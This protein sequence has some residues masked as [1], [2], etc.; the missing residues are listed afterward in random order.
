MVASTQRQED[1]RDP[2]NPPV[3]QDTPRFLV[4]IDVGIG[5]AVVVGLSAVEQIIANDPQSYGTIDVLCNPVQSQ[6]FAHDPRINRVITTNC[7][8]FPGPH[9]SQWLQG[10]VIDSEGAALIHFLREREYEAVMPAIVA[11]G[12]FYRLHSR[13]M[14]PNIPALA[15]NLLT[16]RKH[17]DLH[18]STV[19]RQMVN[20]YF[21]NT[22]SACD[23]RRVVTLYLCPEHEEKAQMVIEGIRNRATHQL[24]QPHQPVILVAP[25]TASIVTRPPTPLLAEALATVLRQYPQTLLCILPGYTNPRAA[26]DLLN[27]LERDC[28]GRVFLLPMEPRLTLL[29]TAAL[30]DQ[31]DVFVTGDT[32]VMHLAAATKQLASMKPGA[33]DTGTRRKCMPRNVR[34]TVVLFG[35][36]NPDFYGYPQQTI[37]VGKGRKEQLAPRPGFS[38]E[39]YN[40]GGR[41]L[42]DHITP[43]QVV[44][45]M[46]VVLKQQLSPISSSA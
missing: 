18:V 5:D 26:S 14:Y 15:K 28:A 12:L 11:P 31:V 41:D 42:F 30:I 34:N 29:E 27:I 19:V 1:T 40:P 10:I 3:S 35:G 39:S 20:R 25:D 9:I 46:L 16:L 7:V 6:I 23:L 22:T 13:L 24:H 32:G 21:G 45:A 36:T 2:Q 4:T 38:K 37:I 33:G 44:D 17:T 8:F 43:Q